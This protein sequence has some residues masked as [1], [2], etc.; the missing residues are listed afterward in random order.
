MNNTIEGLIRLCEWSDSHFLIF[1]DNVFSPLIY[2][3]YF[4]SVIPSLTI[5]LFVFIKGPKKLVN[6]LLLFTIL[7]FT[8]WILSALVTWA[9]DYPS[10]TMFFWSALN[11]F[12]PFVYFFAFY[13]F[14]VFVFGKDLTILQKIIFAS[15]LLVTLTLTPTEFGLLG[16]NL[17][18]CERNASE[19]IVAT[20]GYFIEIIY[21]L[22]ILSY[23][24]SFINGTK[25][26]VD[27]RKVIL[28]T[29]GIIAFLLSFSAGN[30]LEVFTENWYI[31]QYG[32][33]GAPVFVGLLAYTIV[34]FK[35]FNIKLIGSNVLIFTLWLLTGSL[36]FIQD[37]NTSHAVT[38]VTLIISIIFGIFVIESVRR[39]VKQREQIEVLAGDLSNA[40][41]RLLEIDKQK[42]EFVSLATHQLR[43]PLTAMKGYSSLMLEGEMGEINPEAKQAVSRIYDS[44]N[45]LTNIVNDYLNISRIELGTMKYSF[46]KH[47]MKK[48]VEDVIAELKPNIDKKGL[49]FTFN[50][51]AN[52]RYIV[53]ADLDKL[54]QVIGNLIDNSLK[55]TPSGSIE[56]NLVRKSVEG[57]IVLSVKDTGVGISSEVMPRLFEKFV[58]SDKAN[59]QN[60]YGTG[61]GLYIAKQVVLAHKGRIWAES[62]GDGK[63]SLFVV[64]LDIEA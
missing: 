54:K 46:D 56:V 1:S 37:I 4:G 30:I 59:K 21:T 19:G 5:A 41:T 15:P 28:I 61:L 51:D 48:I 12:E 32:L 8:A 24:I 16:Y 31:G 62:L 50:C 55:Y 44:A 52:Y 45:T 7:L 63:G 40:N 22:I 47:D 10:Y 9:T 26:L 43:A 13:F 14:Y 3:S 39:E 38:A 35:T 53:H 23:S 11:I 49:K 20:Y 6:R 36:L 27:K 29:T 42:S 57:K 25:N 34:K 18:D 33:F 64:E 2:Y 58:R 17:T 60:I